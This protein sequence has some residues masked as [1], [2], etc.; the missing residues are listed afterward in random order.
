MGSKAFFG[1]VTVAKGTSGFGADIVDVCGGGA[2]T[3]RVGKGAEEV[4]DGS[5]C[6]K[7]YVLGRQIV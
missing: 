1:F 4:G 5:C 6:G 2:K 7:V 3:I